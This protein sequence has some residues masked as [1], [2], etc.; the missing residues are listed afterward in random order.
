MPA[1]LIGEACTNPGT[2]GWISAASPLCVTKDGTTLQEG[3]IVFADLPSNLLGSFIM[4]FFQNSVVLNLAIPMAVA[5]LSPHHPFQHMTIL[6]K[7]I[8]TGFC[9]SLTTYSSW[10]SEMI[11]IMFGT[12]KGK[13]TAVWSA[14][15]GYIIGMETALGSFVAGKSLARRFHKVANK[16]LAEEAQAQKSLKLFCGDQEETPQPRSLRV[17]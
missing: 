13:A 12:G 15:F 4:G 6:H 8:T 7:G 9:G 17:L 16:V 3:G 2:V 14:L 1:Q 5:W 11:G 10:N